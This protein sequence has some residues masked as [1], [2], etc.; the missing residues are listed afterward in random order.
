MKLRG[1]RPNDRRPGVN[2][3]EKE[4]LWTMVHWVGGVHLA[5]DLRHRHQVRQ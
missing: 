1:Q 5:G 2:L 3:T 4:V